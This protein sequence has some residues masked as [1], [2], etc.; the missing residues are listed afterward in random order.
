MDAVCLSNSHLGYQLL[1]YLRAQ[2]PELPFVD[3]LHMEEE[4]VGGGYPRCSIL[5]QSQIT[6]TVVSSQHL[7]EW[8]V[9]HGLD[10]PR[11]EVCQTNIDPALW[12]RSRHDS[13]ALRKKWNLEPDRPVI[14]YAGRIC[15]QKQPRVFGN[16]I[17]QLT[18]RHLAFTALVAGDGP[19]L[20]GLKQFV[21]Q[22]RLSQVRFL[23]A[24][25]NEAMA[26][27]L[28]IS[29]VFLPALAMGGNFARAL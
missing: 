27:L 7:K 20:P 4:A 6:R 24:V 15:D 9:S 2:F 16:V 5:Y 23:G 29:D 12:S 14:L 13:P 1:P 21:E 22:K 11:I 8:M 26:E 10:A 17:E 25:P 18:R 3:Y 28:A 19:D